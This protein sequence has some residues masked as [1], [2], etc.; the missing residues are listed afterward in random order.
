MGTGPVIKNFFIYMHVANML[1]CLSPGKP[2][3]SGLMFASKART[4]LEVPAKVIFGPFV[5]YKLKRFITLAKDLSKES[6]G[7]MLGV[8]A[9]NHLGPLTYMVFWCFCVL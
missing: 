4:E 3:Q 5:N 9:G 2:F 8:L 7:S 1:E 6:T